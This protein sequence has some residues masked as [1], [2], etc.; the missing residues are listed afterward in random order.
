MPCKTIFITGTDTGVGKTL[1]TAQLCKRLN[2][3]GLRTLA[4]KPIG[5]GSD[6]HEQIHPYN[7][8]D[9]PI[10]AITCYD[11]KPPIAPHIAAEQA[12]VNISLDT[13]EAHY[14]Q[15]LSYQPDVLLIEGAGGWLVPL[16]KT[17]TWMDYV[18]RI[19]AE[20]LLVVGMKLGCLNHSLLTVESMQTNHIRLLGWIANQIEPDMLVL[21]ENIQSLKD[22]IQ[23]RLLAV[24]PWAATAT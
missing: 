19:E 1:I 14:Q 22:S 15:A 13:L 3:A 4:I 5:C 23:A 24:V 21:E 16:N 18:Q 9:A 6:D 2:Q 10:E 8:S 17:Q 12:Q 11:F 20:V 7:P